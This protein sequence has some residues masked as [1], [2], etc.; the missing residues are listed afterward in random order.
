ME[1]NSFL[2]PLQVKMGNLPPFLSGH[3]Q[4]LSPK[5]GE[6]SE[7]SNGVSRRSATRERR[8]KWALLSGA[9]AGA[10]NGTVKVLQWSAERRPG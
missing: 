2:L 8:L 4:P 1:R 6:G 9:K 3:P 10:V 7:E 5:R